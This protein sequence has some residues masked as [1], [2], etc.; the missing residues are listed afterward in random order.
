MMID[1]TNDGGSSFSPPV[2]SIS[3]CYAL[4]GDIHMV[5]LMRPI[6]FSLV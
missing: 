6:A 4:F 5:D 2:Y 1:G 3:L